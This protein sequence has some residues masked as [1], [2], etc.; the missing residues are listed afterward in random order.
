MVVCGFATDMNLTRKLSIRF[1]D[2]Q[3]LIGTLWSNKKLPIGKVFYWKFNFATSRYGRS[4]CIIDKNYDYLPDS[5]C[6]FSI[7]ETI[8]WRSN[9]YTNRC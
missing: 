4:F 6:T 1:L 5:Y 9:C 2:W 7:I 8:Y 3:S